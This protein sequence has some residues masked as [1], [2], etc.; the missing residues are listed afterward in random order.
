M[1]GGVQPPST[2]VVLTSP[3][4]SDGGDKIWR[5]EGGKRADANMDRDYRALQWGRLS[6]GVI[7]CPATAHRWRARGSV[8]RHSWGRLWAIAAAASRRKRSADFGAHVPCVR[9]LAPYRGAAG[10]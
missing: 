9:G 2:E 3:Q 6:I 10:E 4:L 7:G 1:D 8:E 5:S